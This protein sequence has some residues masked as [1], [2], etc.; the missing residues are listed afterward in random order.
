[1]IPTS[2]RG[3][4]SRA[5]TIPPGWALAAAIP[6]TVAGRRLFH[7]HRHRFAARL[8]LLAREVRGRFFSPN[9]DFVTAA[10]LDGAGEMRI[11]GLRMLPSMTSHAIL[12]MVTTLP[13]CR[14]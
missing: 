2:H 5:S 13:R 10:R 8:D 1:M 6:L 11:I 3:A 12:A 7:R 9:E 14:R 4:E